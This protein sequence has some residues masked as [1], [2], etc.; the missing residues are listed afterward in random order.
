MRWLV[1]KEFIVIRKKEVKIPTI[2]STMNDESMGD[3]SKNKK[4]NDNVVYYSRKF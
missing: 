3:N 1:D 4:E 2:K